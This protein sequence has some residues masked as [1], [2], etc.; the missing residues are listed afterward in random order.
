VLTVI[1]YIRSSITLSMKFGFLSQCL[2]PGTR[3][4]HSLEGGVKQIEAHQY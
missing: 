4:L 2:V 3:R 1:D